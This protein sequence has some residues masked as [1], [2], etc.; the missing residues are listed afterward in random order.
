M[1]EKENIRATTA[2]KTAAAVRMHDLLGAVNAIIGQPELQVGLIGVRRRAKLLEARKL[3]TTV[4]DDWA[5][6]E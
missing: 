6:I 1:S 2:N 3:V 4:I 5:T